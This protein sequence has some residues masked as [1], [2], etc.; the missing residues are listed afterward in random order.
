MTKTPD[1]LSPEE[2]IARMSDEELLG[3]TPLNSRP[4]SG[5]SRVSDG[6]S[7]VRPNS[8]GSRQGSKPRTGALADAAAKEKQ[9]SHS[10]SAPALCGALRPA[11]AADIRAQRK[12]AFHFK[13]QRRWLEGHKKHHCLSFTE[14]EILNFQRFFDAL[15]G[16]KETMRRDQFEDMLVC[17]DLA[18]SKKDVR[19]YLEE[20]N[21]HIRDE[22]NFEDFLKAF[23]NNLDKADMH[24]LKLLLQGDYDPRALEHPTFL[25]ERRRDLIFSATGARGEAAK[26]P[27]SQIVRTFE[28]LLED[29]CH[30]DFGNKDPAKATEDGMPVM[31][32][33]KTMWQVAC[34]QHGLARTLTAEERLGIKG[35]ERPASPTTVVKGIVKASAPKTLGVYRC[36]GTVIIEADRVSDSR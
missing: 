18:K 2:L 29:R 30:Q 6:L 19:D 27:C 21:K 12:E 7:D 32:G 8:T 13:R 14:Q 36:G 9:L 35:K 4:G 1:D 34:V 28:D 3:L 25:S 26:G 23:E 16:G 20:F 10:A 31:G 33:L 17:L 24:V 22:I 11:S 15:T 5:K